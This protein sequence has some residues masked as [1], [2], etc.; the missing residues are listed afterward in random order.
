MKKK[1][2]SIIMCLVMILT[3]LPI[4]AF[5]EADLSNWTYNVLRDSTAEI[6]GYNGSDTELVFPEE[7]DGYTMVAIADNAFKGTVTSYRNFTSVTI[8]ETYTRIGDNNFYR[9]YDLAEINLPH[10]LTYIGINSFVG[11]KVYEDNYWYCIANNQSAVFYIGEYLIFSNQNQNYKDYYAINP[12]TKLI[13]TGAFVNNDDLP[14]V[15]I[16]EGVE[17]IGP[18]AFAGC[19]WFCYAVFPNTL[20]SIGKYAFAA[21]DMLDAVVIPEGV[22]EID[23]LA[24]YNSEQFLT[25]YGVKGSAAEEFANK[26]GLEFIETKDIVYGDIDQDGTV[27]IT[28]YSS[29]KSNVCG[30]T[31]LSGT[32]HIVGDMNSDCVIDAFDLFQIDR[33]VNN[34]N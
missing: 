33:T 31:E 25:I 3:I 27:T 13:A 32:A 14:G 17:Y 21:N 19:F 4:Y 30:E 20:K 23:E 16:P 24:F 5:A 28:D 6:T 2:F 1:L 10:T 15:I 8:P 29:T 12:G 18:S 7:I 26:R 22:S 11:T 9:Y 34:L